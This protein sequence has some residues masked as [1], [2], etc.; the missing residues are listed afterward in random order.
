MFGKTAMSGVVSII[1]VLT[2]FAFVSATDNDMAQ[3]TGKTEKPDHITLTWSDDPL[4]TQTITWR[5]SSSVTAGCV[6]YS[7]IDGTSSLPGNNETK[8]AT[9]KTLMPFPGDTTQPMNI[10]TVTLTGLNSGAKYAYQVSSG[11]TDSETHTFSTES[12]NETN[13]KFL[14]F[15]DSQSGDPA[16][17]NYT[18]WRDTVQNAFSQ[19][20]DSR[21]F[22]NDGDLVESG[23]NYIHWNNWF[24][25]AKGVIDTISAMPVQ[26]NHETYISSSTSSCTKPLYYTS[27]FHLFQNGPDGLKGQV[28]AYDY[29]NVHFVVL[30]SQEEEEAPI[31]GDILRA[32][33]DW[34]DKDLSSTHKTWKIVFFHKPPYYNKSM[35]ANEPVKSAFCPIFDKYHVDVVFNGHDHGVSRTYPIKAGKLCSNPEDGTVYY[36]TGRSGAKYYNDLSSKVWNAFFYDPQEQPGYEAVEING[37]RLT[38][39]ASKKDGT[40]IDTYTIEKGHHPGNTVATFPSK[41]N[42]TRV[43]IY[44]SLL[45]GQTLNTLAASQIT[46]GEWFVDANAFMSYLDG[47]ATRI[48][49]KTVLN[50]DGKTYEV[51][52]DKTIIT[53]KNVI[54]IS[55]DAINTLL[56]FSCQYDDSLNILFFVK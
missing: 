44:G 39:T 5:T 42:T 53:A 33:C 8:E 3:S 1:I 49:G 51:P 38:I 12:R 26:G 43:A 24:E 21:F 30:D 52:A 17:P 16:N 11:G 29:G 36:V 14:L 41:Y 25:A 37:G 45:N 31:Y 4:T 9:Y 23:Q 15:G 19:N 47:F 54:T 28:Y 18:P 50:L 48:E 32:Q 55:T 40:V 27:Q 13:F 35:R 20:G 46:N 2:A 56:G 34:L 10:F 6:K 22:V 7:K